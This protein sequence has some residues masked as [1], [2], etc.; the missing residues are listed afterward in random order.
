MAN[1]ISKAHAARLSEEMQ[2]LKAAPAKLRKRM[3]ASQ[4]ANDFLMTGEALG[5]AA[6]MGF[7]RGKMEEA[8]GTFNIPGTTVDAEAITG[9]ALV[10]V[11][12][13]DLLR[14]HSKHALYVGAGILSHYSGQVARKYAKT[15]TL[16]LVAG[17]GSEEGAPFVGGRNRSSAVRHLRRAAKG[18]L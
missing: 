2:R 11:G 14:D 16:S 8:D 9:L 3:A 10:G 18:S 12:L 17:G 7:V 15:G 6:A 4:K 1:I 5:G 13:A